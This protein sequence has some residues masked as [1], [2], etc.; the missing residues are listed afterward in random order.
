MKSSKPKPSA[1]K[2]ASR[3]SEEQPG[4][5]ARVNAMIVERDRLCAEARENPDSEAFEI[6]RAYLLTGMVAS[7]QSQVEPASPEFAG[8]G[9]DAQIREKLFRIEEV[10]RAAREAVDSQ[11]DDMAI[12]NRIRHVMGFD[13][14][15]VRTGLQAQGVEPEDEDEGDD[16]EEEAEDTNGGDGGEGS[17]LP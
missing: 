7:R 3:H 17:R 14:P 9:R 10:A 5:N 15:V 4:P 16:E 12:Y 13:Q 1:R 8:A 11:L 6:M 2:G